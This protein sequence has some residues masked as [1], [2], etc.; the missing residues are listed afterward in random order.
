MG[1][2]TLRQQRTLNLWEL[3][4]IGD[5]QGRQRLVRL[6]RG[7]DLRHLLRLARRSRARL[8]HHRTRGV[9]AAW[10]WQDRSHL[11]D[12]NR[13]PQPQSLDN[14]PHRRQRIEE[15][16]EDYYRSLDIENGV[17]R[18]HYTNASGTTTYD[19]TYIASYPD[20]VVAVRYSA[21]GADKLHLKFTVTP[22]QDINCSGVSYSGG[23]NN[24]AAINFMGSL[25]VLNYQASIQIEA[26]DG[27]ITRKST[28][29]EVDSASEVVLYL[30]AKTNFTHSTPSCAS[31][32]TTSKLRT[33]NT[34]TIAAA[35]EKGFDAVYADHVADF[36]S[37]I[38]RVDIDLD[39]KSS[40][41]T[42]AL[43]DYYNTLSN[44]NNQEARFL[45]QLY[46]C[47]GR[48]LELSSS[49]GIAVPSN[50]QGIWNNVSDAPW[51]SDIHTNIN[52]QM[53]YWPAEPTNLSETHLPFLDY[54]IANSTKSTWRNAA[55]TYG[56]SNV[57]WTVL[58]E[59][60]IFGGMTTWGSNY[61]VANAWYCSHL[62]Q[63]FRFTRDEEFLARAFP[64][65]WNC[66]RFW[67]SRLIEDRGYNS[68]TNN[69]GYRG[70]AYK[71]SPDGTYV[72]PNEFSPEQ[73][74]HD[75]ED[76]TAHAQQL[77][78]ALFQSVKEAS[79]ILGN[80]V[81]GL[82]DS[83]IAKLDE[84]LEKT[85]RGLH[86]ETYTANTSLNGAWGNPRNGVSKGTTILREWKYSPYDVSGDPDHRHMSHLMALYPLSDIGPNSPYFEPAVNSMKLRGDVST[87]WSMGWKICLWARALD[88][89]HAHQILHNAFHHSTT[90]GIDFNVGAGGVYYNLYDSHAPFQIDGNFGTCA[91]I[92]EMLLQ[93]HTD[94]LQLLPALPSTWPK[95]HVNGLKAV[96]NFVV[97]QAWTNGRLTEATICSQSGLECSV[98]YKGL[99]GRSL[100]DANGLNVEYTVID[101]NTIS[102]P[103]EK[104][105]IYHIDM[106]HDT[107]WENAIETPSAPK[108]FQAKRNGETVTIEGEGFSQVEVY[109]T[110]GRLIAQ[111]SNRSVNVGKG[112]RVLRI[113]GND[114]QTQSVTL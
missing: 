74:A 106:R 79:D 82:S 56:G 6:H 96:G 7:K 50:L 38:G 19:R 9:L 36:T 34:K 42:D 81:T 45:E 25:T 40:R 99:A 87:G 47:Y 37:F 86:T 5:A 59:S 102:F 73:T 52:V 67:M 48:Y 69:S 95:G 98:T 29:I 107:G 88:G 35:S 24:K 100:T 91:G 10:R 76:G 66:A 61:V 110:D 105:G 13:V 109:S 1:L 60:N 103:T 111:T 97:D 78:Y 85:D 63:H 14:L 32:E 65:M 104:G 39:V 58:T 30:A 57:G 93:S 18:V 51:G 31:S 92:G 41:T 28:Y 44:L 16:G 33:A 20:D 22:G 53:N 89:D 11:N 55:R 12:L 77:I 108:K 23:S 17:G 54:I 68:A 84:Y 26:P 70:P 46:F 43:I 90:Y 94:T 71:F 80:A 8:D 64:T 4:R 15:A 49:R 113:T 83:D 27:V 2:Q 72:A 21:K 101:K 112:I 114:K 75:T 62:W 3:L